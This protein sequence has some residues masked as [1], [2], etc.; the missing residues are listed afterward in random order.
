MFGEEQF[1][2]FEEWLSSQKH[3]MFPK[4]FF[5]GKMAVLIGCICLKIV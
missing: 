5:I 1:N 4:D 2:K 3:S